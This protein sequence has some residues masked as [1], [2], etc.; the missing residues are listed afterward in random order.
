MPTAALT[1]APLGVADDETFDAEIAAAIDALDEFDVRHETHA[2][3]TTLEADS[4]PELFDAARGAAEA[5]DADRA[6]VQLTVDT[7]DLPPDE[8]VARVSEVG[9]PD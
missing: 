7:G 8:K 5:V 3:E 2:M 1:V 6:L 9:D 4:L